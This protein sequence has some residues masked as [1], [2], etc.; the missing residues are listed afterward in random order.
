[1]GGAGGLGP[2][3]ATAGGPVLLIE[4]QPVDGVRLV[5]APGVPC[6]GLPESGNAAQSV[7]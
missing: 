3:L 6:L 5:A 4:A 2:Y 7:W 1:M